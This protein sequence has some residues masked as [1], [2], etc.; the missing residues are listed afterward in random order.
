MRKLPD[1]PSFT[2]ASEVVGRIA[3]MLRVPP[4]VTVSEAALR[5]RILRN[6]GGGFT[7][8]YSFDMAPYLRRIHDCLAT[9]G[10]NN[11]V[12]VMGPGQCGKSDIG[13]N[14]FLHTAIYDPADVIF[15]APD[16]SIMRDYVVSQI[17]QMIRTSPEL[18]ELLLETP[19]A[20][21]IF[22]KQFRGCTWFFIWPVSSQMRARPIPRVR[23]DDYDEIPEDI[24]G[25]GTALMLLSARQTAFEGHDMTYVNSSPALGPKRGIEA[26]VASGTD[27]RWHVPC[28]HCGDYFVLDFE[29]QLRFKRDGS[30]AEAKF[31]AAV[32][33]PECGGVMTQADKREMMA[34]GVWAGADQTVK[35]DGTL[36]GRARETNIVSFRIDGLMGL[37]SWGRLAELW[38][39]ADLAFEVR[40]D[41][42]DLVAFYNARIG[43]NYI[44]RL[45]EAT[46]IE[47]SDLAARADH[48]KLGE[49]PEG[50]EVLTA[51]VD[52]QV[53][54]F[55]I[56]VVGWKTGL[57]SFIVDRFAL[58]QVEMGGDRIDPARYPEHWALLLRYVLWRRYPIAGAPGKSLA[59]CNTA[60]DTGGQEG[61]SDNAVKFWY[62]ARRVGV[63]DATITMIKGG[64]NLK[65]KLLSA[66]TYLELDSRGRPRRGGPKLYVINVNQAKDILN[67][68]LARQTPGAGYI[69]F[70]ADMP[71]EYLEELTAEEKQKGRWVKTKPRNETLDLAAYNIAALVRH[72]GERADLAW[73]PAWARVSDTPA[74][75]VRAG[76]SPTKDII[77]AP[78]PAIVSV[79][80]R[81]A[82]RRVS[83]SMMG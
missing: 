23:V 68:R 71:N 51:A 77:Q 69:H 9:D 7:G 25:Q 82:R 53:N 56:M 10:G 20:D 11:A 83:S 39:R 14:W 41:E 52:V 50:V 5:H 29:H 64:M 1:I 45:A 57:E 37:G 81:R 6:P 16:K 62:T 18:H 59:I 49:V 46:A 35:A 26:L 27:E 70:A 67:A 73:V 12:A 79:R 4:S 75:D 22:S 30:P 58:T 65:A 43:M 32:I 13:N 55:E 40:Q 80:N 63:P 54:R 61:V 36:D 42:A 21:N 19:S 60:I 15:L 2:A 72:G 33:C 24:D 38:R 47:P 74:P 8:R 34:A 28:R 31:S 17:N 3:A 66:P 48:Y 76:G 78:H 44:S